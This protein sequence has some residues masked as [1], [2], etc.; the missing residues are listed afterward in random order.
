[1]GRRIRNAE[2]RV[3]LLGGEISFNLEGRGIEAWR[4]RLEGFRTKATNLQPV[5]DEFGQYMLA[6]INRNFQ[7]E[8]RPRKWPALAPSTIQQRTRQGYGA[9]PILYRT[10]RL[11]RGFR[12]NTG[13]TYMRIVND[14]PYFKY[15]QQDKRRGKKIPRRIMVVLLDQDKAQFTRI[16][17]RYLSDGN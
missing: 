5:F 11:Q 1:M 4:E 16:L 9:G 6:S 14:T 17:R 10:G 7:N 15:H 12:V 2:T 13:S 3:K 8:G